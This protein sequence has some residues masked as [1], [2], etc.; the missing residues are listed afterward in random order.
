MREVFKPVAV[1][2]AVQVLMSMAT[3]TLPVLAPAA[4]TTI[5]VPVAW[6]GFFIA[7]VYGASMA[8]GLASGAL[9]S[10]W[11][12]LRVSQLCLLSGSAGLALTAT[13]WLPLVACG[14]L[15][16]GC[17][18]GP[19]TPA[20][21]HILTRTAPPRHLSKVFSIKQT[22][23]PL[24]AALAGLLLPSVVLW[25]GWR[26]AA[27]LVGAACALAALGLQPLR[28]VLD[29]DRS[30]LA[31]VNL[32]S[33]AEPVRMAM[34][35]RAGRPMALSS[36]FFAALQLCLGT[37]LV[38]YLTREQGF[39]LVQAGLM[40]AVTQ[41]AGIAGRLLAGTIAD[42]TG[43]PLQVMGVL[44]AVMGASAIAAS[45]TS[46]GSTPVLLL[47]YATFGASAIG[48][49]GVFLAEVARRA[50]AG[51][52]ST[53]TGAAL[54][55]T[56][57]GVLAG[58]SLFAVLIAGGLAYSTAFLFMATPPL[59]CG[60]YLLRSAPALPPQVAARDPLAT[61]LKEPTHVVDDQLP[62]P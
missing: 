56:F 33:L 27:L 21:S 3:V 48:W 46:H 15:L 26:T 38:T 12:A 10:R 52:V 47:V 35:D 1:T 62:A 60:L 8:C 14:A 57:G 39:D 19:V 49:N 55:V 17:G 24:G 43:R 4:A 59:L 2:L 31:R 61:P 20:S 40:L 41:G 34:T 16:I 36:F 37:Y 42:H 6:V 32:G 54:L 22:G 7:L 5:Q 45:F 50:P 25:D 58:P 28:A 30:P 11:G 9:V 29:G 23:V 44:G 53:A 18:Y 51:K 13:G